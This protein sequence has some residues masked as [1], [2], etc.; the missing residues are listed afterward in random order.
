MKHIVRT[1]SLPW[2]PKHFPGETAQYGEFKALWEEHGTTQF[3][4]RLTRIPPCGGT[5]TKYHT[6]TQEEE[7]FFVLEGSCQIC[8]EGQWS[9]VRKGDSIFKPAGDFHIFRNYGDTPCDMIMIGTNIE[10]SEV[11]RKDEP[12]PPA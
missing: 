3:E 1:D 7:W 11:L 12:D 2:H 6:H 8:I 10:G 5:N 9:E 4:V